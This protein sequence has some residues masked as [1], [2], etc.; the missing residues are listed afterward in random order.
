M[1]INKILI[2]AMVFWILLLSSTYAVIAA[3]EQEI[4]TD[5]QGDVLGLDLSSVDGNFSTTDEKPNIDIKKL[6]YIHD[7]GSTEATII[8]EV[9]GEIEDK[10]SIYDADSLN[11]VVLY[12]VMLE[13]S[14]ENYI[15]YY[16][17]K[18]CQMNDE[19]ITNWSVNGGTLN[20][21]FTLTSSDETYKDLDVNAMDMD[22]DSLS[23]G[24]WYFDTYP[25]ESQIEVD[26]GG[27]YSGEIGE[28]IEFSGD[29][30]NIYGTSNSFSYEW[31]FG[32]GATSTKQNP[33]HSYG[34]V[35]NYMVTF[36]VEDDVGNTGNDSITVTISEKEN[37]GNV[38][39]GG[40][41]Q[42]GS[43]SGLILFFAVIAIVVVV[44][45]VV[46]FFIIRR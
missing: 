34:A 22:L 27:P 28:S 5:P 3:D 24:G 17:N 31:D 29:A 44:G 25:D 11:S 7:D 45:V 33:T 4:F 37:G 15:L 30:Y 8:L 20:I 40:T 46:L 41:E 14:E 23:T 10:G 6:T 1:K 39:G 2:L 42:D 43:D 16:A 18:Q 9:Y 36:I 35:G 32:D 21:P 12:S 19:N 26:A 13:T 38:N